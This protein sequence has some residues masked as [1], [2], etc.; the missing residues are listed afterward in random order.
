[1][2]LFPPEFTK[3]I[4]IV[5]PIILILWFIYKIFFLDNQVSD[6]QNHPSYTPRKYFFSPY[7]LNFYNI[8]SDHLS[9]E[10]VGKYDL[11]P[12]V[13]LRDL[14]E[15]KFRG[16]KN[17]ISQKHIDFLVVDKTNHCT[18]ILAIELNWNS[19]KRKNMQ[20]SD[21]FKKQFFNDIQI[22]F[23]TINNNE[24]NHVDNVISKIREQL[25]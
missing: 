9:K 13:R 17:K 8:L 5:V 4:I 21:E 12:K 2:N 10:Y 19:H 18:P 20:K 14:W 7:E 3:F 23:I 15:G 24:L 11:F 25:S 6:N 22:K 1:M 16:D